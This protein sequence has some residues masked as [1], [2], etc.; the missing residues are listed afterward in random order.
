MRRKVLNSLFFLC[1]FVSLFFNYSEIS[2][3]NV[4]FNTGILP[5]FESSFR[6]ED[7]KSYIDK[8]VQD[9]SLYDISKNNT[10]ST[11]YNLVTH[12][13]SGALYI[14][15]KWR[16]KEEI[17]L[18]M[19]QNIDLSKINHI[20][21][22]GCEFAK[23]REGKAAVRFLEHALGITVAASNNITGKDGDWNLEIGKPV[24]ALNLKE[25]KHKFQVSS[26]TFRM[27]KQTAL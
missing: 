20:N 19:L 26:F 4:K 24:Q 10:A 25:Y 15:N 21:I 13:K 16:S 11:V 7:E 1:S 27:R 5:G 6:N 22:Y 14:E 8:S 23:G 18:W 9:L 2:A 3:K 12:G 17:A